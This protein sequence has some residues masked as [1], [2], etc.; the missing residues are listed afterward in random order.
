MSFFFT[1]SSQFPFHLLTEL[2][3]MLFICIGSGQYDA[4]V[5][6]P[7]GVARYK[8]KLFVAIPR[9]NPGIPSTLNVVELNGSP[10]HLNPLVMGYPNYQL[11]ELNVSFTEHSLRVTY[12]NPKN[13]K[14]ILFTA[15][16]Q[17]NEQAG[18]E[19][20]FSIQVSCLG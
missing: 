10:P 12:S 16:E 5:N 11:N 18:T 14:L 7:F 3:K 15:N 19:N 17:W 4:Y 1:D 20:H 6:V 9:R 2:C 13:H 8:E